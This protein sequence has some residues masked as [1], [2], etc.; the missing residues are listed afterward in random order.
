VKGPFQALHARALCHATEDLDKVKLAFSSAIGNEDISISRTEGHHG[1]PIL[2][3]ESEIKDDE[4]IRRFFE[5]FG[6]EDLDMIVKTIESRID[7]KCALYI[8]L[9]KQSA[10]AGMIALGR[11]DDII[12]VRLRVRAYPARSSVASAIVTE[13]IQELAAIRDEPA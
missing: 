9:D 1:N 11:N 12:S 10:L 2:I 7:D 5:R 13:F 3:L 4:L 6:T 8:R